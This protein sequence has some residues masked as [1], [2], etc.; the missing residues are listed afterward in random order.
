VEQKVESERR[1]NEVT[2]QERP[3]NSAPKERRKVTYDD[4]VSSRGAKDKTLDGGKEQVNT[5]PRPTSVPIRYI[6]TPLSVQQAPINVSAARSS[7]KRHAAPSSSENKLV[8]QVGTVSL[9]LY[10][11]PVVPSP[12]VP[13]RP[14][15][16]PKNPLRLFVYD[17][18]SEYDLLVSIERCDCCSSHVTLLSHDEGAY[19]LAT[20]KT[21]AFIRE[22]ILD[23]ANK[24]QSRIDADPSQYLA[25]ALSY[26]VNC[27][28][29]GISTEPYCH[30]LNTRSRNRP[31]SPKKNLL[32]VGEIIVKRSCVP[33]NVKSAAEKIVKTIIQTASSSSLRTLALAAAP[34]FDDNGREGHKEDLIT[35]RFG[36]FEVILTYS[37]YN[38]FMLIL[39][40]SISCRFKLR[41]A[42][43]RYLFSFIL[44]HYSISNEHVC[45]YVYSLAF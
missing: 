34:V 26:G 45:V 21:L 25:G 24:L 29:F 31:S 9:S 2:T 38:A 42:I 7:P 20:R 10:K 23:E 17:T 30:E 40:F 16:L 12:Q 28:D 39:Y 15:V 5:K 6:A 3:S 11:P 35:Q 41:F 1:E 44:S 32:G 4:V 33:P 19:Q 14:T 43:Q 22:Y 13:S 18:L 36:A 27:T 8:S 37:V